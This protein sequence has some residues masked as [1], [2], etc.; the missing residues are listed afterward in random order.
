MTCMRGFGVLE[1]CTRGSGADV[2]LD[3][4]L[5]TGYRRSSSMFLTCQT[6]VYLQTDPC[7]VKCTEQSFTRPLELQLIFT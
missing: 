7:F 4:V 1:P 2:D 5:D 3:L 6:I